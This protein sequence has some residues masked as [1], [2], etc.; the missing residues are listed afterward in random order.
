[1]KISPPPKWRAGCSPAYTTIWSKA[2]NYETIHNKTANGCTE[3]QVWHEQGKTVETV[4][5]NVFGQ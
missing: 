4:S 3:K 5:T 2:E 1:M